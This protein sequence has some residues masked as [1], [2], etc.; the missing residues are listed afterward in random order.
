MKLLRLFRV[1]LNRSQP[2]SLL[3]TDQISLPKFSS[4][5]FVHLPLFLFQEAIFFTIKRI[6]DELSSSEDLH[7]SLSISYTSLNLCT[8]SAGCTKLVFYCHYHGTR[9]ISTV[10]R[11]CHS[12]CSRGH[13]CYPWNPPLHLASPPTQCSRGK[14]NTLG[15]SPQPH[16]LH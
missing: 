12:L 6:T 1:S 11:S 9:L 16:Q 5:C 10:L 14:F 13:H 7:R 2:H 15:H 8:D 4:V 3:E